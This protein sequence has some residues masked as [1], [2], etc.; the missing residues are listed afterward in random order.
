MRANIFA[1]VTRWV[2]IIDLM[3]SVAAADDVVATVLEGAAVTLTAEFDPAVGPFYYQWSKDGVILPDEQGPTLHLARVQMSDAGAYIVYVT[4]E[5]G[6]GTSPPAML[7]VSALNPSRLSSFSLIAAGSP[8]IIGFT[9]SGESDATA[10]FLIRAAGP[11][12]EQFG[13]ERFMRDPRLQVFDSA[14]AMAEND[15]WVDSPNLAAARSEVAAFAFSTGSLDSALVLNVGATSYAAQV[16]GSG[17]ERGSALFE[18]FHLTSTS[19]ADYPR[20]RS[21]SARVVVAPEDKTVIAG[22][23]IRGTSPL[24][25]LARAI[26]PGL[27]PLGIDSPFEDPTLSLVRDKTVIAANDNWTDGNVATIADAVRQA[28]AFPS[29]PGSTDAALVALLAPGSYT[30]H[31]GGISGPAGTALIELYELP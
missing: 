28:R 11:A 2:V 25:I 20:L 10:P 23:T 14:A 17:G 21:I 27:S 4:N 9:L 31:L 3:A 13:V 24:R 30:V 16:S 26:G 7:R 19:T 8:L 22:F 5:G 6:T 1:A 12:L 15:N 18:L 29:T